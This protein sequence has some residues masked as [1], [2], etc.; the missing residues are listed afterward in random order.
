MFGA[1]NGE[2]DERLCVDA[3]MNTVSSMLEVEWE[4]VEKV[5][6]GMRKLVAARDK[7]WA[8]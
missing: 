2:A 4:I 3:V 6:I 5:L 7:R 1:G 8:D